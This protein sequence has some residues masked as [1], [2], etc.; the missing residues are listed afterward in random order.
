MLTLP[1][2]LDLWIS[3]LAEVFSFYGP[4]S[5]S[6]IASD[7]P[8]KITCVLTYCENK[9]NSQV[10]GMDRLRRVRPSTDYGPRPYD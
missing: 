2:L 10:I 5:S 4:L 3:L 1:P 9:L 6:S 7:E 8:G